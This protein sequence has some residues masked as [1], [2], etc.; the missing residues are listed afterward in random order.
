[1]ES[2]GMDFTEEV[3]KLNKSFQKR[4]SDLAI[5]KN[6]NS[7]LQKRFINM[8]RQCWTNVQYSR[9][10]CVEIIGTPT[11]VQELEETF[12]KIVDKVG[13]KINFRDIESCRRVGSQ[14]RT[15]AKFSHSKDCQK[16]M[17]VKKDLSKLNLTDKDLGNTRIFIN[18]SFCPYYKLLWSKSKRLHAMKQ[19]QSYY[20]SNG[21]LKVKLGENSRPLSITH[22]TDFDKHSAAID[23][24]PTS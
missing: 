2:S 6:V 19:I 24:S 3:H 17:K 21:T 1:M 16:L 20:I 15:I 7:Q 5:T 14:S 13:V 9:R 11:S 8:E 22:A 12:C 4:T 10:E 18:H 23:L